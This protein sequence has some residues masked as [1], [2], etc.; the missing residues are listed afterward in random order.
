MQVQ[1]ALVIVVFLATHALAQN[2][3]IAYCYK[4]DDSIDYGRTQTVCN[5]KA[6]N[7]ECGDC[8][9]KNNQ[10]QSDGKK[11]D[12]GQWTDGCKKTGAAY[13]DGQ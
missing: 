1:K 13:G 2:F 4:T 12:S 11:I 9:Y 10:C 5:T 6:K 8:V 7:G 3:N